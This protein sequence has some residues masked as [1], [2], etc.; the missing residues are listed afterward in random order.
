M[1]VMVG[2]RRGKHGRVRGNAGCVWL[3]E[4]RQRGAEKQKVG[5]GETGMKLKATAKEEDDRFRILTNEGGR[6]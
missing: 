3:R 2:Q 4:A 1:A 5:N 6:S